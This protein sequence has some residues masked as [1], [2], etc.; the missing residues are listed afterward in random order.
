MLSL[1]M[2]RK[3]SQG[4]TLLGPLLRVELVG[5]VEPEGVSN[6]CE[7]S[8]TPLPV[9]CWWI[10][11]VWVCVS[12]RWFCCISTLVVWGKGKEFSIHLVFL[13]RLGILITQNHVAFLQGAVSPL[14]GTVSLLQGAVSS[15]S[16]RCSVSSSGC[17]VST[18]RVPCLL[19]WVQCLHFRVPCLLF[20]VH[21]VS[22]LQGA[23]SPLRGAVSPLQ[24]AMSPLQG[25]VS[26]PFSLIRPDSTKCDCV[27][28]SQPDR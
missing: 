11:V 25:A 17:S 16:S 20:R 21:A 9:S 18:S 10:G 12:E 7:S 26:P 3:V 13:S 6:I 24:G 19:F 14:Q 22:P 27:W 8:C 2:Q 28:D 23:M 5:S 15:P 1:H 4:H